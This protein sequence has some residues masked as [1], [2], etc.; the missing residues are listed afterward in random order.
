M[1]LKQ[2]NYKYLLVMSLMFILSSSSFSLLDYLN[3]Q[4]LS[5]NYSKA[6]LSSAL[7]KN[8][9]IALTIKQ[10]SAQK[11]SANWLNYT[12]ELAKKQPEYA[13]LLAQFYQ[14]KYQQTYEPQLVNKIIFWYQ[15]AIKLGS[16]HALT[17]LAN[18]YYIQEQLT[19][20]ENL[21]SPINHYSLEQTILYIKVLVDQGKWQQS[22]ALIK[23]TSLNLS[24][25]ESGRLLLAQLNR[26]QIM[27][28][29]REQQAIVTPKCENTIQFFA[30]RLSDL[31]K[32]EQL[33]AQFQQ[34][35]LADFVCFSPVRYIAKT[36]LDCKAKTGEAIRC[37]EATWLTKANS[38]HSKYLGLL[39]PQGGANVHLGM[40]YLDSKDNVDVFAHEISHLLGFIDEYPLV[41]NHQLCQQRQTNPFSYNIVTLKRIYQGDRAKIRQQLLA[42]IPWA[43]QIKHDT[44]ILQANANS[45]A[46]TW[47]LGTPARYHK[48]V[49]VFPAE[50]CAK[51]G[52]F[53]FKPL[54]YATQLRYNEN[55]FP[56]VYIQLLNKNNHFFM[57]SFRYNLTLALAKQ[58]AEHASLLGE[59]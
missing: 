42:R 40:I 8:S 39:L 23:R 38:I 21:L 44:P 51:G 9:I 11:G 57:P 58:Q 37:N 49:G 15:Q 20:A 54:A 32:T 5:H 56:P 34:H 25:S 4:L 13:F 46:N 50:T 28:S 45:P 55:P 18:W 43:D 3:Q 30:T 31:A 7:A 33:I 41:S 10:K 19:Q 48:H 22:L 26:Y 59:K 16:R 17:A 29:D 1:V 12:I 52:V 24:Q 47:L 27:P 35:P 53:A 6:Q 2:V 36:E 14:K